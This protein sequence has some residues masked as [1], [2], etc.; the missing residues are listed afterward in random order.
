MA[1]SITKSTTPATANNFGKPSNAPRYDCKQKRIKIG[2][3][4]GR[5]DFFSAD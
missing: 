3:R 1:F 4:I 2:P 5:H